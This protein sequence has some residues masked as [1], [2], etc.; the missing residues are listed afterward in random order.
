V[1]YQRVLLLPR[2]RFARRLHVP[3][4]SLL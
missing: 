3:R 4:W 2:Q 1:S